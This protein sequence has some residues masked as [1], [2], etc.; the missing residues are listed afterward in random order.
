MCR[1]CPGRHSRHSL[2]SHAVMSGLD[3]YTV[4]RLL[5]HADMAWTERYAHLDDD[6]AATAGRISG[7]VHAAMRGNREEDPS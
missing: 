1:Q 2:A 7:I 5:G 3:L 6:H 4:G